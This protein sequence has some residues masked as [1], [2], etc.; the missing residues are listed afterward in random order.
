MTPWWLKFTAKLAFARVPL[1]RSLA[2]RVGMYRL[3]SMKRPE[4]AFDCF[5]NHYNRV[6]FA[7]KG[8]GF[9]QLELGPG[10]SL[11]S[12]LAGYS[13]GCAGTWLVDAGKHACT[14]VILYRDMLD[15]IASKN[16]PV[17]EACGAVSL[18]AMLIKLNSKYLTEGLASLRTIPVESVGFIWSNA[19]LEHIRRDEFF[20]T[21]KEL[22]RILRPGGA[23]SHTVDLKD[24]L[25]ASLNHLRFSPEFWER[26]VIYKSG[27]YTNRL[28][29]SEMIGLFQSA[30]FS[31]NVLSVSRW[32]KLPLPKSKLYE[33][34]RS[35][36]DDE[37]RVSGFNVILR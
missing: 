34:F 36:P 4:C 31:V 1:A 24:H 9:M 33:S 28:R 35:L 15:Y 6:E 21:M 27:F 25:G 12:A 26:D 17:P 29:Y 18:D 7:G 3:G 5:L 37:L 22:R 8:S 32:E 20:D 2:S 14:D 13:H 10:D 16:L 23:C 11:F 19:V 30:G